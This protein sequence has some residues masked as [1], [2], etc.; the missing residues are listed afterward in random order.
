MRFDA[1]SGLYCNAI[2]DIGAFEYDKPA[3]TIT[4]F[5]PKIGASLQRESSH[6]VT[7][8]N[9]NPGILPVICDP[10]DGELWLI[11]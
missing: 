1:E 6:A 2:V 5:D 7:G 4:M 9:A 3:F 10:W 11:Y 8:W